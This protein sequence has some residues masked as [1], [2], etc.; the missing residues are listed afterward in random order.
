MNI[1]QKIR[2]RQ[3]KLEQVRNP[4]ESDWERLIDL[5]QPGLTTFKGH[6]SEGHRTG[7]TQYTSS[8]AM[9]LR[10]AADGIMGSMVS[11]HIRW[12]ALLPPHRDLFEFREIREYYQA[13]EEQVYYAFENSNLYSVIPCHLRNGLAIGNSAIVEQED[14]ASGDILYRVPHPRE[15]YFGKNHMDR[16]RTYH[17]KF[18][19]EALTARLNFGENNLSEPVKNNLRNDPMAKTKFLQV[20]YE[21]NDPILQGESK[22]HP[23]MEYY[24][25][26]SAPVTADPIRKSGYHAYPV[27]PWRF[28][29]NSDE[30]Y[31]RGLGHLAIADILGINEVRA[32]NLIG[33]Q[34][35]VDQPLLAPKDLRGRVNKNPGGVT[36]Y[37]SVTG[38]SPVQ[39]LYPRGVN[40][41]AGV[42]MEAALDMALK[43]W[44]SVDFFTMLTDMVKGGGAP[45]T[46]TQVIEM[47]GEKAILLISRVG[48]LNSETLDS[49]VQRRFII[50]HRAGRLPDPP[51]MLED[52]GW[53]MPQIDYVGPLA[54]VQ[55]QMQALRPVRE[56]MAQ[57]QMLAEFDPNVVHAVKM[58]ELAEDVLKK[59]VGF[60]QKVVRTQREYEEIVAM[61]AQQQ[62]QQQQLENAAM[63]ADAAGKIQGKTE[64]GS[65]LESVSNGMKAASPRGPVAGALERTR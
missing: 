21:A 53:L 22:T 25:D 18:E 43:E 48:R 45:P 2:Q 61:I 12:L 29:I 32:G 65:P 49:I 64:A 40:V 14:P 28:E 5:L 34:K 56:G 17:R 44:F 52:L 19:L 41:G 35:E 51:A 47:A 55:K 23:Y 13:C 16:I 42:Q 59:V 54:Q 63:M 58:G 27:S 46:A 39:G 8:P 33:H 36:Y 4:A 26:L 37:D 6:E 1:G 30:V 50:E 11:P 62:Q 60:P 38:T 7:T 10:T 31:G 57:L 15:S 3:T 20:I 9:H 24:I